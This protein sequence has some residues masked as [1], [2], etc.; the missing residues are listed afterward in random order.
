M[1]LKIYLLKINVCCSFVGLLMICLQNYEGAFLSFL[2][3]NV[4]ALL[5][6]IQGERS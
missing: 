1:T 2:A 5:A 6:T 4:L 3:A